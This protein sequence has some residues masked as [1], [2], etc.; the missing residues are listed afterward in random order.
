[1]CSSYLELKERTVV[2]LSI[3]KFVFVG[4]AIFACSAS[5]A[6]SR[7]II[8]PVLQLVLVI[9]FGVTALSVLCTTWLK[10]KIMSKA[11]FFSHGVAVGMLVSTLLAWHILLIWHFFTVV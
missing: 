1:M 5:I 8:S 11:V 2:M 4:L 3:F 9:A 10:S 6:L 7:D